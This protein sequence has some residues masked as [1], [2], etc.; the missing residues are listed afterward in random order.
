MSARGYLVFFCVIFFCLVFVSGCT[1]FQ[2]LRPQDVSVVYTVQLVTKRDEH[3]KFRVTDISESE[4]IGDGIRIRFDDIKSVEQLE[5]TDRG[6]YAE[7]AAA[8]VIV[9]AGLGLAIG[10]AL[11]CGTSL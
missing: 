10:C 3:Y 5:L 1:Q 2:T 4:I 9:A 7:R 11:Y 8:G 6:K